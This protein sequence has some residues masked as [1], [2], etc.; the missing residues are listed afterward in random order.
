MGFRKKMLP[1]L[2]KRLK[3]LR[4]DPDETNYHKAFEHRIKC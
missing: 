3:L 2:G 4:G 1:W